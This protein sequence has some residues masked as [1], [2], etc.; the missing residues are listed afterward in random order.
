MAQFY[1]PLTKLFPDG[2]ECGFAAI[3]VAIVPG[4]ISCAKQKL[5]RYP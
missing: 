4:L 5:R 1:S 3:S 2:P